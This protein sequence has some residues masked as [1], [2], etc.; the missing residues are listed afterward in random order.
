M[1]VY[2]YNNIKYCEFWFEASSLET[3]GN[4]FIL[5]R[6]DN[7]GIWEDWVTADQMEIQN[8]HIYDHGKKVIEYYRHGKDN[9]WI[10]K[11]I[12]HDA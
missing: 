1:L 9:I 2:L 7:Q 8:I 6:L 10:L 11:E 5:R 12:Q 3:K 4:Q